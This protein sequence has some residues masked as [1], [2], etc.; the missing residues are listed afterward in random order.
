MAIADRG[1]NRT[2]SAT[3]SVIPPAMPNLTPGS[4]LAE[5]MWEAT[6]EPL[7]SGG[8]LLS[9]RRPQGAD[10]KLARCTVRRTMAPHEEWTH[11]VG[12]WPLAQGGANV[13]E[14]EVEFPH[15]FH[16]GMSLL[17]P[18][19]PSD[20]YSVTWLANFGAFLLGNP[21]YR[22]VWHTGFRC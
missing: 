1:S 17:S 20:S 7:D 5:N 10:G 22:V 14:Y 2:F 4:V 11:D 3:P 8:V 6:Q 16:G 18:G 13:D 12:S 21:N 19:I 15:Q 9:I